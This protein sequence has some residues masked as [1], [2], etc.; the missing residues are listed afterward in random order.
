MT[1]VM[2]ID[3]SAPR[4]QR[5]DTAGQRDV[6]E[7]GLKVQK[8]ASVFSVTLVFVSIRVCSLETC[9][10]MSQMRWLPGCY[11]APTPVRYTLTT[12]VRGGDGCSLQSLLRRVQGRC[13]AGQHGHVPFGPGAGTECGG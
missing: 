5:R 2:D 1:P 10:S 13:Q 9:T 4:V 12:P 6:D 7:F 3:I 11:L 8:M